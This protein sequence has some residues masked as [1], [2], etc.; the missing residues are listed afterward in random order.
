M[1]KDE[2]YMNEALAL[3][4]E[5]ARLGEVPVG[6]VVVCGGRI[7]GRGFNKR[8]SGKSALCHAELEAIDE[9]CRTLGGWRLEQCELYVT[10][11]PCPMCAG[12]AIGSRIK[13]VCYGADDKLS[14]S[15]RSVTELFSLPYPYVPKL[16]AGVLESECSR[17]LSDFFTGLRS[18]DRETVGTGIIIEPEGVLFGGGELLEGAEET[19][20]QLGE[21]G[22]LY[23]L[24]SLDEDELRTALSAH[25]IERFFSAIETVADEDADRQRKIRLIMRRDRIKCAC[26]IGC[27]EQERIDAECVG[28]G[29]VFAAYGGGRL[30][31]PRAA[32]R[33]IPELPEVIDKLIGR[34]SGTAESSSIK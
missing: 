8:E 7:A 16:S 32:A 15:C 23:I 10:L 29:F 25:G 5:A 27:T 19:L 12:A 33:S 26:Y 13:R 17:V 20:K 11:E 18:S 21:R 14:G 28:A 6:A 3:A 34:I 4:R 2:K 22:R 31:K 30:S 1:T 24:S 9:A